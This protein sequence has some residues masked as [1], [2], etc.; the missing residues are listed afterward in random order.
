MAL[1]K[2]AA[3][4]AVEF[5][6]DPEDVLGRTT[7]SVDVKYFDTT[8]YNGTILGLFFTQFYM[9]IL[10]VMGNSPRRHSL[11]S[12][13]E[14]ALSKGLSKATDVIHGADYS[15]E[16]VEKR[17]K[18]TKY[19]K[20]VF[21]GTAGVKTKFSRRGEEYYVPMSVIAFLQYIINVLPDE[22]LTLFDEAIR[23]NIGL[24]EKL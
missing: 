7:V 1:A 21:Y 13:V 20:A 17:A 12:V 9:K 8:P 19:V 23:P 22:E 18:P 10:Y 24:R 3:E 11:I 2:K 6:D 14:A 4:L 15:L 5:Y 16:M